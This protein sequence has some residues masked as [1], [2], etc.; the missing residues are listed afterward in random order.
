MKKLLTLLLILLLLVSCSKDD[1]NTEDPNAPKITI[2][3][4]KDGTPIEGAEVRVYENIRPDSK[5]LGNGYFKTSLGDTAQYDNIAINKTN[6]DGIVLYK[7]KT[8]PAP[9]FSTYIVDLNAD[10]KLIKRDYTES[11]SIVINF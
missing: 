2:T 8:N 4:L 9:Q 7:F 10:Y 11:D 6:R 1:E 5:Y 3:V